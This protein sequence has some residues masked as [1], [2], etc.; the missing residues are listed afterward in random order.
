MTIKIQKGIPLPPERKKPSPPR[1]YHRYPW[2]EMELGDSFFVPGDCLVTVR[3]AASQFGR[4]NG[5]HFIA[6]EARW[7]GVDGVRAWRVS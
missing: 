5:G 1:A 7:R 6:R 3:L 4:R 2:R